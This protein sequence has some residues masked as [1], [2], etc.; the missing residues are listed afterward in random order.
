MAKIK[1]RFVNVDNTTIENFSDN[2]RQVPGTD[3]GFSVAPGVEHRLSKTTGISGL[4]LGQTTLFTAVDGDYVITKAIVRLSS[5]SG[6]TSEGSASIGI[7]A[8]EYSEIYPETVLG[9]LNDI[10]K[11]F[12]FTSL[13]G[14][15]T[16]LLQTQ[17]IVFDLDVIYGASGAVLEVDLFGYII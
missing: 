10:G 6:F 12:T 14:V 15:Q 17:S 16:I 4:S 3:G 8:P 2:L 7:L 13:L 11:M 9:G 1:G 5:I